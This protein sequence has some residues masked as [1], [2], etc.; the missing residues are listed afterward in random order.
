MEEE[1]VSRIIGKQTDPV[2][3]IRSIDLTVGDKV[4]VVEGPFVGKT[5][6]IQEVNLEDQYLK[7]LLSVFG[8]GREVLTELAL[9]DV[10]KE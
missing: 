7:V 1:E 3:R 4:V 5:G 2:E 9:T 8:F 10:K 6:T